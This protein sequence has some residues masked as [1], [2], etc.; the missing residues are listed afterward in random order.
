MSI[1]PSAPQ[2]SASVS[3]D[4][5]R[6]QSAVAV[7]RQRLADYAELCRPK[8][9]IMTMV[10]VAVGFTLASPITF[11]AVKLVIAMLGV[12]QL[13]AASSMLNQ[14]LERRTDVLM[15]RTQDRPI[16]SGRISM[17]EASAVAAVLTSVG[18]GLLWNLV[19]PAA[20][21]GDPGNSAELHSGVHV[22]EDKNVFVHDGRCYSRGDA[23]SHWLAGC[24]TW[25]R[26]RSTGVVRGVFCMAVSALSG[27]R[28]DSP[29]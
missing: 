21:V 24:R 9:A 3:A 12:V 25:T 19:N 15:T 18:F 27:D 17:P 23:T 26:H 28:L 20:G 29:S 22:T 4:T 10:A 11:D 1:A 5:L 13:V 2:A 16:A 6:V 8:I 14:C 7:G